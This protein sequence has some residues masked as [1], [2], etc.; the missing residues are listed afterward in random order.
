MIVFPYV[1][2]LADSILLLRIALFLLVV[3]FLACPA[4]L[5]PLLKAMSRYFW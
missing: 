5:F 3:S 1:S 2:I 4:A